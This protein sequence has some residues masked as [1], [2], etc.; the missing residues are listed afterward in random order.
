[1][2]DQ[3]NEIQ[4]DIRE[5][6]SLLAGDKY[7]RVGMVEK[8]NNNHERLNKLEDSQ[9]KITWLGGAGTAVLGLLIAFKDEIKAFLFGG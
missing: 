9:K 6:R 2:S 1:M 3:L 7:G 8:Q 4:N 5:I